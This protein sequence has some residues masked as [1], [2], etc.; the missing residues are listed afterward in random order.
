MTGPVPHWPDSATPSTPLRWVIAARLK[1]VG[2]SLTPV[3]CG[4]W[5]AAQHTSIKL[6]LAAL[7]AFAAVSIQIGTNLWN[8]AADAQ[9]GTDTP[10]RP[11]PSRMTALGLLDATS[12]KKAAVMAFAMALVAGIPLALAGGWPIM[13]IGIVSLLLGYAYSMGPMPLSHTPLGELLVIAFFGVV[14]VNGTAHVLGAGISTE[15]VLVGFM[16]GLPS[17]AVLLLNNHRDRKTDARAGRRTLAIVIGELGAR[18]LYGGL[19]L[20]AVALFYDLALHS[21][22]ANGLAAILAAAA[23]LMSAR[24]WSTP[25]SASLNRFLPLTVIFQFALFAALMVTSFNL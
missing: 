24:V 11:G 3:L 1:T 12:V 9:R 14:A 19:L 13:L 7:A 15:G 16:M 8:D 21:A 6:E 2:L 25:V 5:I 20:G 18:V 23:V 22:A 10:E 4:T 17:G